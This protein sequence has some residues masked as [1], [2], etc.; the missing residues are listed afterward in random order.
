M[1]KVDGESSTAIINGAHAE[2]QRGD[3]LVPRVTSRRDIPVRTALD[4]VDGSIVFLPG[5]RWLMGTADSV[6]LN[7][8]SIHGVEVG[9]R[10]EVYQAGVV[11]R[12]KKM[13]DSVMASMVVISVEAET[14]VA[15]VTETVRELEIGDHVRAVTDDRFA[16]R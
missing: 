9:T 3:R 8:G 2:M 5:N 4:D 7:V 15:F 14:C 11:A 12:S 13:P 16:V 1:T 10:M 6:Y